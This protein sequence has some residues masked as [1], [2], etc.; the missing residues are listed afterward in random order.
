MNNWT[1][2]ACCEEACKYLNRV[3]YTQATAFGTVAEW[4]KEFRTL[5]N[6]AHPNPRARGGKRAMPLLFEK[7][8]EAKDAIEK[9]AVRKLATLTIE[10]VHDLVLDQLVP[11]L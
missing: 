10:A 4:N 3:G 1:W 7:F 8:P 6:F 2:E 11:K 9:F 5:E